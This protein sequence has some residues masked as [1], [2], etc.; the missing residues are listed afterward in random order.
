MLI[1]L[2]N[3]HQDS[4]IQMLKMLM[5]KIINKEVVLTA[6]ANENMTNEPMTMQKRPARLL[7]S[8]LFKYI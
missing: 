1:D 4:E 5:T 6:A 8:Y 2:K 7:P 3:D